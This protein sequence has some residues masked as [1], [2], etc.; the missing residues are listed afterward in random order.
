MGLTAD[1]L[2]LVPLSFP[3][4]LNRTGQFQIDIVAVDKNGKNAQIHMRFPLTVF[5]IGTITSGK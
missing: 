2:E 5:D 3:L 1:K 4:Y